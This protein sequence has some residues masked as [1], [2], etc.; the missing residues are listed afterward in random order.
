VNQEPLYVQT[1]LKYD[2]DRLSFTLNSDANKIYTGNHFVDF[3]NRL[4]PEEKNTPLR[5][6]KLG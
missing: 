4:I 5:G 2:L 6:Q 1:A 3:V